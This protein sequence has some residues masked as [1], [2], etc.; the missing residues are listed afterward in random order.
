MLCT[1]LAYI[2]ELLH[3]ALLSFAN[4][5]QQRFPSLELLW[6]LFLPIHLLPHLFHTV[7]VN[8][9]GGALGYHQ[10][11]IRSFICIQRLGRRA[12]DLHGWILVRVSFV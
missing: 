6:K 5:L 1:C 9:V 8:S 7:A 12:L 3:F 2:A 4:M 10:T 11:V